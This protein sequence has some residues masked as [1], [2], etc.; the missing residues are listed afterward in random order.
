MRRRKLSEVHESEVAAG[1][2]RA[3]Q[4]FMDKVQDS[5]P[6]PW[7]HRKSDKLVLSVLQVDPGGEPHYFQGIN[8]EVSLPTGSVCA[9]RSAILHARARFP[10]LVRKDFVGIAV[11]EVPLDPEAAES[12]SNPMQPCGA[13]REWLLKLQ[14]ERSE[15]LVVTYS[16]TNLDF[17][18]E[19][20]P[21]GSCPEHE[22]NSGNNSHKN[23]RCPSDSTVLVNKLEDTQKSNGEALETARK[24]RLAQRLLSG[25]SKHWQPGEEFNKYQVRKR[26]PWFP[27]WWF[28]KLVKDGALIQQGKH[29]YCIEAS[30]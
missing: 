16:S 1:L 4:T 10:N 5:R 24:H 26:I 30:E 21:D 25:I 29:S 15:F 8:A 17:V 22:L 12:L 9:E 19:R 2:T 3:M 23:M 13:C 27:S 11:L 20:F 7:F 6:D 18:E 14:E 28:D